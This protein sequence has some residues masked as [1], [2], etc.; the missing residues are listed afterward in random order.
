MARMWRGYHSADTS[1]Q[2][3]ATPEHIARVV[4]S[5]AIEY[6]PS[7]LY[8]VGVGEGELFQFL[9]EKQRCGW[10]LRSCEIEKK[11]RD[12][13]YGVDFLKWN[14]PLCKR[15][16]FVMNPPFNIQR[17][18][19]THIFDMAENAVVIGIFGMSIRK[20]LQPPIREWCLP[21]KIFGKLVRTVLQVIEHRPIPHKV[22]SGPYTCTRKPHK[23]VVRRV[24]DPNQMGEFYMLG[25]RRVKVVNDRL[26][27]EGRDKGS[28][29]SS[30]VFFGISPT[31]SHLA[32][33]ELI[34]K[35][36]HALKYMN[37]S[38]CTVSIATISAFFHGDSLCSQPEAITNSRSTLLPNSRLLKH[39]LNDPKRRTQRRRTSI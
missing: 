2:Y 4:A 1:S 29:G 8:D 23:M 38:T 22:Y 27:V 18:I 21:E 6:S 11:Y 5:I 39:V 33:L 17:Q 9:P 3:F 19:L 20:H 12:V 15:P 36:L 37:T 14:G 32:R 35:E 25:D 7:T 28:V 30:G 34:R 16:V 10:E 31:H 13:V 26:L 24:G